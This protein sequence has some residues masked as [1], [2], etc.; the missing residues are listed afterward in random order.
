M[1]VALQ[2]LKRKKHGGET[3]LFLQ[4]VK[5]AGYDFK[6]VN[7]QVPG[8]EGIGEGEIY[9]LVVYKTDDLGYREIEYVCGN[10]RGSITSSG[11]FIIY[12]GALEKPS[13]VA[14]TIQ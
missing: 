13:W 1:L 10:K 3:P 4:I 5:R 11:A 6:T 2:G 8:K 9:G 12:H 7:L 14:R